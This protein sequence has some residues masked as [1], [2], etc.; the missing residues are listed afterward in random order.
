MILWWIKILFLLCVVLLTFVSSIA[1]ALHALGAT[2]TAIIILSTVFGTLLGQIAGVVIYDK[3]RDAKAARRKY[4]SESDPC[5][6]KSGR[7]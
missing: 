7:P 4:E 2:S 6:Q 3:W 5:R 1:L